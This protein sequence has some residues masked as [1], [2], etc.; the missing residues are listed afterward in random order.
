MVPAKVSFSVEWKAKG[1]AKTLGKGKGVPPTDAAA[2][3]GEFAPAVARGSYSGREPPSASRPIRGQ[4]R[5]PAATPKWAT[6]ATAAFSKTASEHPQAAGHLVG[7]W[8]KARLAL[9]PR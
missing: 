1:P 5:T 8:V 9:C 4:A 3:T 7:R 2:F 6:N